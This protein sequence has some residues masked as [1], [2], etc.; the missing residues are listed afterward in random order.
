MTRSMLSIQ[1]K[2][3]DYLWTKYCLNNSAWCPFMDIEEDLF[4]IPKQY[5][6]MY[7]RTLNVHDPLQEEIESIVHA[8]ASYYR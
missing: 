3:H 2:I 7:R 5:H 6:A 1:S 4:F 8:E